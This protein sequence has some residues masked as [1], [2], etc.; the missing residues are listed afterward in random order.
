MPRIELDLAADDLR[1]LRGVLIAARAT[2]L[3][4]QQRR[5]NRLSFGYGSDSARDGMSA[6]V[7]QLAR[8]IELLDQLLAAVTDAIEAEQA[9]PA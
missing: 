7:R 5:G 2:E 6:E 4:E 8:R 3:G 1:T 9:D